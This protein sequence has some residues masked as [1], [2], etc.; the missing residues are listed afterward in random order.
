MRDVEVLKIVV[1]FSVAIAVALSILLG[2]SDFKANVAS[3]GNSE[4]GCDAVNCHEA[5]PVKFYPPVSGKHPHHLNSSYTMDCSFCHNNYN[6]HPLHKNGIVNGFN[7]A[8]D[9]QADGDI[10]FF[11][12]D[13]PGASWDNSSSSCDNMSCH[14]S[15]SWY[16]AGD[17]A[18]NACHSPGTSYDP[19]VQG[20][21]EAHLDTG[22]ST[23][24]I[25]CSICHM[26]YR[27]APT[28]M[29]GNLDSVGIISFDPAYA[30]LWDN[31]S[32]SCSSL[33]CHGDADWGISSELDCESCH[34]SSYTY[35]PDPYGASQGRHATHMDSHDCTCSS[36]H[37]GYKNLATHI[38]GNQDRENE[39]VNLVI[40]QDPV[41]YML[42]WNDS[43]NSCT[44]T[45]LGCHTAGGN[46]TKMW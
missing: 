34:H 8:T 9:S 11:N 21:H 27:D 18:C 38:D 19:L 41:A 29:D 40:F 42:I 17:L 4:S 30:G 45:G 2:C 43:N 44:R 16:A 3:T 32:N 10:I 13:N 12:G 15:V 24:D 46:D 33:G 14:G 6:D 35:Y 1:V 20:K 23:M 7:A 5:T 22:C 36:C 39:S 28:H 37:D 25:S 31:G 26:D